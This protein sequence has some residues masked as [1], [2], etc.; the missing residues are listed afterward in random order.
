MI[1]K[2]TDPTTVTLENLDSSGGRP[3]TWIIFAAASFVLWGLLYP[4]IITF[5]GGALFPGPANGSLIEKNAQVVGSSLIGQNFSGD[6]YFIG[7]PS[8]A[9]SGN[10]PTAM[11][12]SNLAP[13]NP[14]LRT[15]AEATS[16]EIAARERI[17]PDQIPV[18][19]IA[20]SGAGVD[21]HISPEAAEIQIARVAKARG[22]T[23]QQVRE[24]VEAN[25]QQALFGALGMPRVNVLELNLALDSTA[26]P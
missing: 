23:P 8:A 24:L 19:L 14:A 16:H 3:L 22:I 1:T 21:P 2:T 15:R 6:K 13:S 25:T 18:D 9:G 26:K 5:V 20:A 7:R 4:V 17:A 10:D 12:G 11:S